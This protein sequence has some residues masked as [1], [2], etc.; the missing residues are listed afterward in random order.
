MTINKA[1]HIP[2]TGFE[3]IKA[4]YGRKKWKCGTKK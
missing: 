3:L 1:P 4:L 2:L